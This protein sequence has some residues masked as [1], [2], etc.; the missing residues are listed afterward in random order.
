MSGVAGTSSRRFGQ[1]TCDEDVGPGVLEL[2]NSCARGDT[3][4]TFGGAA[5][6]EGER[7]RRGLEGWD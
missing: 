4:G 6:R 5:G 3:L 2:T 7:G 1:L